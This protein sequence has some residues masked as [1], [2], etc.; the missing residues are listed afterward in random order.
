MAADPSPEAASRVRELLTSMGVHDYEPRVLHQLLEFQQAYLAEVFDDSSQYAEHAGRPGQLE[1]ED[2]QLAA[3]LRASAS[4]LAAPKLL[5]YMAA[6]RNKATIKAPPVPGIQLPEESLCL[7][8]ANWQV[9]PRAPPPTAAPPPPTT[10]SA[11]PAAAHPGLGRPSS[12]SSTK[13]VTINLQSGGGGSGTQ[14][15]MAL[16]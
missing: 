10:G 11:R 7:V 12:K 8:E 4:Q 1:C 14:E 15:P 3:R 2:V 5:D 6:E 16:G 13:R 9:M